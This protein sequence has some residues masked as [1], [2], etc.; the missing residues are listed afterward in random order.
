MASKRMARNMIVLI[1]AVF[2]A[3]SIAD[4][5]LYGGNLRSALDTDKI[6]C[7][8]SLLYWEEQKALGDR[9]YRY[10]VNMPF[11]SGFAAGNPD[12]LGDM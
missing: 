7:G 2:I 5:P 10:S 11:A 8:H 12:A 9:L 3:A 4:T 6:Y 1:I